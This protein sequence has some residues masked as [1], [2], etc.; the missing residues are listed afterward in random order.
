[1]REFVLRL[2]WG[3]GDPWGLDSGS[4]FGRRSPLRPDAGT[5]KN[6]EV[7]SRYME[8]GMIPL[9]EVHRPGPNGVGRRRK[10][11]RR[12]GKLYIT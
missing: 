11:S 1:M 12:R 9:R 5:V 6:S 3:T 2:V 4:A 8:R 10:R 7:V